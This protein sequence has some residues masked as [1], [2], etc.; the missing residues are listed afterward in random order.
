MQREIIDSFNVKKL[1]LKSLLNFILEL[2]NR[3]KHKFQ[4]R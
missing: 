1:T 3:L 4:P 2:K